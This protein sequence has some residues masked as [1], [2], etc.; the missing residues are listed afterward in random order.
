M[1]LAMTGSVWPFV[2]AR[3]SWKKTSAESS[4]PRAAWDFVP[5]AQ[6]RP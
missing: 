1:A 6:N 3:M 5:A 4:T 2:L